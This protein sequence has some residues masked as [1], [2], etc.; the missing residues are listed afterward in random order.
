MPRAKELKIRVQD[1]PGMLGEI[2]SALGEKKINLRAV[3]AWVEGNEGVLRLVVDQAGA[4]KRV[5]AKHG[6]QPEET[7]VLE[8]E[9]PDKPGALGD[10]AAALGKAGVNITHLFVGT[11][12]ARKATVF[13]GVSD[14]KAALKAVR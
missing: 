10:A 1:R 7:E 3:S 2:A 8:L 9:L 6:W 13:A 11:A 12:G 4:A 14:L 5:L